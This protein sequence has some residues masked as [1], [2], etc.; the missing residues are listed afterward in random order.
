MDKIDSFDSKGQ[1]EPIA[2]V[3]MESICL[4]LH[5]LHQQNIMHRDIKPENLVLGENNEVKLIDFGFAIVRAGSY[6]SLDAAGTP[7]YLAPE[8]ITGVYGK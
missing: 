5:H 8:V 7:Y 1:R 4:A 3:F 6:N 2:A